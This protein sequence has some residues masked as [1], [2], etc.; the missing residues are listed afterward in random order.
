MAAVSTSVAPLCCIL[1]LGPD[2]AAISGVSTHLNQLFDSPLD[3][4]FRLRHF[5]VGSEGRQEGRI[6]RLARLLGSPFRL[7]ATL[8]AERVDIVHLNTSLNRRAYWRDLAYLLVARLLGVRVL[9]QVHGGELP[10]QFSARHRCLPPLLRLTLRLPDVIVVLARKELDAYQHF[11]PGATIRLMPNGIDPAPYTHLKS[12]ALS[13]QAGLHLLYIGRLAREKGL[14]EALHGLRLALLQ[15]AKV[16][17][18]IAGAGPDEAALRQTTRDLNLE[19]VVSF[20][21]PVFAEAKIALL[22]EADILLLPS[23]S[24]GL[25]YA[26]LEGMAAG[27]PTIATPVGAIPDVLI[28]RQH[29]VLVPPQDITAIARAISWLAANP[30]RLCQMRAACRQRIAGAYSI[31]RL[32]QDFDRLYTELSA[33]RPSRLLSRR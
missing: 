8:L 11:L 9:Y 27:L 16:H 15:A 14:F 1:I 20:V 26:L 6:N 18:T 28:D 5:Q 31:R 21:G 2:R 7:A 30:A 12:G 4:N 23:Y 25:P 10:R 3:D 24:E 22:G 17:L 32:I 19:S 33:P 13:A 29:G